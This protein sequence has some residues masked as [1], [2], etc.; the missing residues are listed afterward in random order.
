[1]VFKSESQINFNIF[2]ELVLTKL[3]QTTLRGIMTNHR[4]SIDFN[5]MSFNVYESPLS[6]FL[7]GKKLYFRVKLNKLSVNFVLVCKITRKILF[8]YEIELYGLCDFENLIVH[9]AI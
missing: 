4:L 3:R 2:I 7:Q 8:S 9:G 6:S 5:L 1:M